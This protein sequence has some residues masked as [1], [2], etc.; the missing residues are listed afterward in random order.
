M[1]PKQNPYWKPKFYVTAFA[2]V[3]A[4]F[5]VMIGKLGGGEWVAVVNIGL[6]TYVAGSVAENKFLK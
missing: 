5:L 6:A 1:I 4:T 3:A 2:L